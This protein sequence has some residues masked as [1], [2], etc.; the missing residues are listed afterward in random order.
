MFCTLNGA[1]PAG[2][3]GFENDAEVEYGAGR[4]LVLY[5]AGFRLRL[6]SYTSMVPALKFA[7]NRYGAAAVPPIAQPVYTAPDFEL[8]NRIDALVPLTPSFHPEITPSSEQNMKSAGLPAW[9]SKAFV[10]EANVLNTTPVT[11]P[12]VPAF[13]A[14]GIVTISGIAAPVPP[15]SVAV[16]VPLFPTQNGVGPNPLPHGFIRFGS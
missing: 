8:S 7:A 4:V 5:G 12:A 2:I 1:N 16:P 6:P 9:T 10:L 15:Y 3:A 14:W 13:P 11:G